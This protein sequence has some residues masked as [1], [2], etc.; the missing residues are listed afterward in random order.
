M[1]AL[2]FFGCLLTAY[3]PA[4][5]IFFGYVA[6]DPTLTI[7]SISSAFF[8]LL[9]LLLSALIWRIVAPLQSS[10]PFSVVVGV[11]SQ[12]LFRW[13]YY[14]LLSRAN[15]LFDLVS[16]HPTSPLNFPTRSLVAGFGFGAANSLVTYVSSLAQSAGPGVVVARACGGISMFFLSAILT[17]LFTLLNIAWN[18]VAFEGYRTRSWWRVAFVAVTHLGASMAVSLI[19]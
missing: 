16:K 7:L 8:W 10:L 2:S 14:M 9:S 5:V 4:L 12:E 13:L 15:S 1:T 3:G 19:A 11:I 17:S 6:R 18:V